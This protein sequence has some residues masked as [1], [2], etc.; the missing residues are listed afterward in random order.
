MR[1]D[2]LIIGAGIIGS[3]IAREL[4]KQRLGR[5]VVLEKE[6]TFGCHASG[7]N[8]G[9]IHSG[10]NQKPGSLKAR[11]CLDGGR[12]LRQFCREHNIPM[13]ECGT[14]VIARNETEEFV[15]HRLLE[16]GGECGVSDLK[17]ISQQELRNREPIANGRCALLSPSGASVDSVALLH[18][19]I[20]D[21]KSLGAEFELSRKA[22]RID[23]EK[24]TVSTAEKQFKFTHVINCAGL[25]A[26]KVAHAMDAGAH[27]KIIPFRGEYWEV[28]ECPVRSMIYQPPNLK[29]PFLSI[30]LTRET[31]GQVLAGPSAVLSLGRESYRKEWN[32]KETKEM[33]TSAQFL[34]LLRNAQ[35]RD[36]AVQNWVTS[37]SASAFVDSIRSLITV[38]IP[39]SMVR[40]YRS[41]IRAQVVDRAGNMVED[42]V[43]EYRD[44]STHVL[45]AVSPGMTCSLPFAEHVV[46]SILNRDTTIEKALPF[47]PA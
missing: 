41:G 5:I 20:E 21:A 44:H 34:G 38:P 33:V 8:S 39:K 11:M 2:Y 26:D 32:L 23:P 4:A 40:P 31:N 43:V 37:V 13:N 1:I 35:F 25:Y 15:L 42:L 24:R 28:L 19:I 3:S 7:R 46:A 12:K 22:L 30:H 6:Q 9:V 18:A 16:W 17:I 47:S 36:L 10:I 29:F 27:L 14:L 45:N